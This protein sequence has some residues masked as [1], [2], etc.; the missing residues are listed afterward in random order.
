MNELYK[1]VG[2]VVPTA[3]SSP[4]EISLTKVDPALGWR[5]H[6]HLTK[7][8]LQTPM[9]SHAFTFGTGASQGGV[10]TVSLEEGGAAGSDAKT[11]LTQSNGDKI[12]VIEKAFEKIMQTLGLDLTNDS[13]EKSPSRVARMFV[14]EMFWGLNPAYFPKCTA[15]RNDMGYDSMV[16]EKNISVKSYCEH[17]FVLIGGVAH[18]AY[19]PN[20][21]VVG[22]SK[23]NRIV[24]YFSR[25]PQIQERLTHQVWAS[26]AY[27][28]G[29]SDVAV[30]VT[31]THHCVKSRGVRD[32][33]SS[34]TTSK[35]GGAFKTDQAV[36]A[37]FFR[38]LPRAHQV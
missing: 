9:S 35:L 2:Q 16:I 6:R 14:N 7:L 21:L 11:A 24:Q 28:L 17:H 34:T 38:A 1:I 15:V 12:R 31:A 27:I 4:E 23:L 3:V 22:L 25:R 5:V 26:L 10:L 19:I 20:E 29:T 37:E 8:G 32:Q 13:L 33:H 18:V 30:V 36:R